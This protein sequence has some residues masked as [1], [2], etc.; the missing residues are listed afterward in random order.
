MLRASGQERR[1]LWGLLLRVG[2]ETMNASCGM[3]FCLIASLF[4]NNHTS[5]VLF[6]ENFNQDPAC[7]GA[8]TASPAAAV[9]RRP[10]D[11][12]H[13]VLSAACWWNAASALHIC[14]KA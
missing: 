3:D 4:N 13:R 7:R 12:D 2:L 14:M 10:P 6:W 9:L 1:L 11:S 5:K 8:R